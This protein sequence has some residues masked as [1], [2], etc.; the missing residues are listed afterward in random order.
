MLRATSGVM[1]AEP[2][3]GVLLAVV[4]EKPLG[5]PRAGFWRRLAGAPGKSFPRLLEAL[6]Y[7]LTDVPT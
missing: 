5:H 6:G 2:G 3:P 4:T 1:A 7:V